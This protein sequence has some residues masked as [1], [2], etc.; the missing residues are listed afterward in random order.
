MHYQ[1]LTVA[2][3][4][5]ALQQINPTLPIVVSTHYDNDLGHT[6]DLR[7]DQSTFVPSEGHFLQ[8]I[9]PSDYDDIGGPPP[10][11]FTALSL[12]GRC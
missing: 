4:I 12:T 8:E 10:Q 6:T 7:V 5:S 11:A 3:L 2:Q 9:E 1:Q